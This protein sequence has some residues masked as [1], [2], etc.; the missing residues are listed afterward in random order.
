VQL[1]NAS[2]V[3]VSCIRTDQYSCNI[4]VKNVLKVFKVNMFLV[5]FLNFSKQLLRYR[6]TIVYYV[7]YHVRVPKPDV[8]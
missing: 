7:K 5:F 3:S 2:V 8:P 6:S 1:L 4:V